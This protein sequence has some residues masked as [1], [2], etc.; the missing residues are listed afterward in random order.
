[1]SA[2]LSLGLQC[3]TGH[4][5]ANYPLLGLYLYL[6][7]DKTRCG[8]DY[9]LWCSLTSMSS[10]NGASID[11][12]SLETEKLKRK[13]RNVEGRRLHKNGKEEFST[14][15]VEDE[16]STDRVQYLRVGAASL[17]EVT[18]PQ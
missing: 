1:M 6:P 2:M 5:G 10:F 16:A 12:K 7:D 9:G 15:G 11:N 18:M 3:G 8:T 13:S 4:E 17:E 14:D